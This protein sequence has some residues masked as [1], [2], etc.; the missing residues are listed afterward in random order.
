M[1]DAANR[2]RR[3]ASRVRLQ[4]ETETICKCAAVWLIDPSLAPGRGTKY[5]DQ[6]VCLSLC[7]FMFVCLFVCPLSYHKINTNKNSPSF[8]CMLTVAVAR[9]SCGS[10][11][12]YT[13]CTSGLMD[14]VMF[15]HNKANGRNQRRRV[16]FVQFVRWRHRGKATN[17]LSRWIGL[18]PAPRI[19]RTPLQRVFITSAA[20]KVMQ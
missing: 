16:C 3:R 12:H 15:S 9:S 18:C 17:I 10:V 1:V 7:L 14:N 11:I 19:T 13:L 4:V 8:L 6:C 20:V 2:R 5:C